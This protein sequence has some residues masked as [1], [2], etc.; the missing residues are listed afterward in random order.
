VRGIV[1]DPQQEHWTD[2]MLIDYLN[3]GL[4][5]LQ[6]MRP[7]SFTKNI[8]IELIPGSRQTT[9]EGVDKL[10]DVTGNITAAGGEGGPIT[11]ADYALSRKITDACSADGEDREVENFSVLSHDP[12]TFFVQPPVAAGTS[13]KV[14]ARVVMDAPLL[15]A[16]HPEECIDVPRKHAAALVDW[17]LHRAYLMDIESQYA[18]VSSA[19]AFE[20]FYR[21]LDNSRLNE[22][23]YGSG[24]WDGEM[25][26]GDPQTTP[27]TR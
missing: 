6:S 17:M 25:G 16:E 21:V 7:D 10:M 1:N 24:Y 26:D 12:Q 4:S 27:R 20:R 9:P 18:R 8:E 11:V 5:L 15:C 19:A 2:A 22:A 23:R 13:R 3:E 14:M